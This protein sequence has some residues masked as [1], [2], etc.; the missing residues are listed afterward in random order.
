[1]TTENIKAGFRSANL[2]SYD[3]QAVLSKLDIKLRTPTPTR[4]PLPE[5]DPWISWTL[6]N[7]AEAISQSEFVRNRMSIH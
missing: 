5:A 1:M 2:L 4:S 7:P 3:P 6:Y